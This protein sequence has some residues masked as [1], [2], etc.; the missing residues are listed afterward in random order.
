MPGLGDGELPWRPARRLVVACGGGGCLVGGYRPRRSASEDGRADGPPPPQVPEPAPAARLASTV[1]RGPARAGR[2]AFELGRL[3]PARE[4]PLVSLACRRWRHQP[5]GSPSGVSSTMTPRLVRPGWAG[6]ARGRGPRPVD[7]RGQGRP[8]S[9]AIRAEDRRRAPC[10]K[11]GPCLAQGHDQ[12]KDSQASSPRRRASR[13]LLD[14]FRPRAAGAAGPERSDRARARCR[15]GPPTYLREDVFF[16]SWLT[17]VAGWH[18][19]M[20]R[21]H[22][23]FLLRRRLNSCWV[24]DNYSG[25]DSRG[26]ESSSRVTEQGRAFPGRVV[27]TDAPGDDLAGRA[28]AACNRPT[29]ADGAEGRFVRPGW[30]RGT[31]LSPISDED[32]SRRRAATLTGHRDDERVFLTDVRQTDAVSD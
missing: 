12:V 20:C 8:R 24:Q 4:R 15:R 1:G 22:V 18:G 2:R 19:S 16:F 13:G 3:V 17:G 27:T 9:G 29:T 26:A 28:T 25:G 10:A 11:G 21:F 23:K 14:Q 31:V 32:P 7:P 6:A 30:Q 5:S